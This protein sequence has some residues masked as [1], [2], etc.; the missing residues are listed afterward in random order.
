MARRICNRGKPKKRLNRYNPSAPN[1]WAV[2]YP[3][4][5]SALFAANPIQPMIEVKRK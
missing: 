2:H 3:T 5:P 4:L 1:W